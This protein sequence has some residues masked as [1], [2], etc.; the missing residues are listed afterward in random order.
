MGDYL[1][2][3]RK[4]IFIKGKGN[5]FLKWI[6]FKFHKENLMSTKFNAR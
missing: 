2:A 1:L 6:K 4:A 5:I 3:D